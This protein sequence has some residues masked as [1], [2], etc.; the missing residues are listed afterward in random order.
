M[1]W[2]AIQR[3]ELLESIYGAGP[4]M[5]LTP[6][7]LRARIKNP[8]SASR[9]RSD[10]KVSII[11]INNIDE[12]QGKLEENPYLEVSLF[13][14]GTLL[15]ATITKGEGDEYTIVLIDKRRPYEKLKPRILK[16]TLKG[17]FMDKDMKIPVD[18]K[19]KG[20]QKGIYT[21]ED[22]DGYMKDVFTI[23]DLS[24]TLTYT[25]GAFSLK[26]WVTKDLNQL[27]DMASDF[28]VI[29]S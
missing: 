9:T 7:L 20:Q 17:F 25:Y 2:I 14:E 4:S 21:Q 26:I 19:T 27:P 12:I 6:E 3:L 29:T 13:F 18:F 5:P 23:T 24:S 1:S 8:P 22:D 11:N 10:T 16:T 28:E 15:E